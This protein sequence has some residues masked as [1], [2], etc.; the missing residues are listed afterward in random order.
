MGLEIRLVHE[1]VGERLLGR[2]FG[3]RDMLTNIAFV[4]AFLSAG[5]VLDAPSASGRCSPS[6]APAGLLAMPVASGSVSTF[7]VPSSPVREG[8]DAGE[9]CAHAVSNRSRRAGADQADEPLSL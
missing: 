7:A 9:S 5:A 6:V 3:L 4:I 2:V 1:L 8:R